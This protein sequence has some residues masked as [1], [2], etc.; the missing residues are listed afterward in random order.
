MSR[1]CELVFTRCYQSFSC[2]VV[3]GHKF[4][5]VSEKEFEACYRHLQFIRLGISIPYWLR[6]KEI[7]LNVHVSYLGMAVPRLFIALLQKTN[8]SADASELQINA[9]QLRDFRKHS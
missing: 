3:S 8:A 6:K 2:L 4:Y 9:P 7:E 5:L 1:V